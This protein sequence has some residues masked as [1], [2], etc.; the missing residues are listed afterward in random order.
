MTLYEFNLLEE[1]DK[2][3][4]LAT[5]D[6]LAERNEHVH[7][8]ELYQIED[9]YIELKIHTATKEH[10]IRTFKTTRLLEQ[11]LDAIPL[12]DFIQRLD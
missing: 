10:T 12:P 5:K 8:Y 2:L 3:V 11:Y 1:K 9:F 7:E 4:E 6:K